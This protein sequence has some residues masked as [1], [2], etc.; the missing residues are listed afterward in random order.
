MPEPSQPGLTMQRRGRGLTLIEIVVAL[1][2][3]AVL[4][5]L[6]LPGFGARADRERLVA[7]AE[8]LSADINEARYE[9]ARQG[10]ALHVVAQGAPAWCWA[11]VSSTDCPCGSRQPCEL[12]S[13]REPDHPGV[14][15]AAAGSVTLTADGRAENPGSGFE[16]RSARG[17]GVQVR[18]GAMGRAHVCSLQGE[19]P[20]H[21]RC[22]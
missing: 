17:L 2:V 4:G 9:A 6:A 14:S 8:A 20:R 1:A 22:P 13:A 21:P 11:V 10:R 12:R 3:L 7:A 18:V 15:L 16:L 5:T 19:L